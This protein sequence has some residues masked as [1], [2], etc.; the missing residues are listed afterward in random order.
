M[1]KPITILCTSSVT[2]NCNLT[3]PHLFT[4]QDVSYLMR[5]TTNGLFKLEDKVDIVG[6]CCILPDIY[7]PP[8]VVAAP[9]IVAPV[10]QSAPVQSAPPN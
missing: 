6:S 10:P 5:E 2:E 1:Y 4:W 7:V 8:P 3:M 9:V